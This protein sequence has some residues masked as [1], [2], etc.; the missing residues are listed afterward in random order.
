MI[1]T[2]LGCK[3][4]KDEAEQFKQACADAGTT[5]N[6]IFRAA[7]IDFMNGNIS[8]AAEED[9][10]DMVKPQERYIV[11]QEEPGFTEDTTYEPCEDIP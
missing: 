5:P 8:S 6:A 1:G 2:L 9:Q 7:M 3:V 4:R 10:I 11:N